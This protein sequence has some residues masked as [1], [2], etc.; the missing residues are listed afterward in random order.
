MPEPNQYLYKI[1]PTRPGMLTHG[2]TPEEETSVAEHFSY[3]QALIK[4]WS[5]N[6]RRTNP[7][8]GRKLVWNRYL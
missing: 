4:M 6:P 2:P 1:Q 3:L 8:H 5:T 7:E